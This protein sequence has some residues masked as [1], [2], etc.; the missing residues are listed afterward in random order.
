M[1]FSPLSSSLATSWFV[2]L[3]MTLK[4]ALRHIYDV[5]RDKGRKGQDVD[6]RSCSFETQLQ[7][8]FGSFLIL[9]QRTSCKSRNFRT[10]SKYGHFVILWFCSPLTEAFYNVNKKYASRSV[11]LKYPFS[12]EM[13][14]VFNRLHA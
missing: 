1:S 8:S 6:P 11:F 10:Q 9:L 5:C 2:S 3:A 14:T 7:D 4:D 12:V 13:V